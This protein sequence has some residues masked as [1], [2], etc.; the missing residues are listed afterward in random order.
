MQVER[1]RKLPLQASAAA[2]AAA[3]SGERSRP[4]CPWPRAVLRLSRVRPL[5]EQRLSTALLERPHTAHSTQAA[6]WSPTQD[7]RPCAEARSAVARRSSSPNLTR[8]RT[9]SY[10][11]ARAACSGEAAAAGSG[12]ALSPEWQSEQR[13][14]CSAT[15]LLPRRSTMT[16]AIRLR[17]PRSRTAVK[18]SMCTFSCGAR[19][20][21]FAP[22]A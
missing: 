8:R 9:A 11:V 2:R 4:S 5:T 7:A 14:D 17:A 6:H 20:Q 3:R 1:R 10:G 13:L 21:P 12:A 19:G 22:P 15:S 16:V 18:L